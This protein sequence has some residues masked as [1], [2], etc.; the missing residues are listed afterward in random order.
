MYFARILSLL[1]AFLALPVAGQQACLPLQP[2]LEA[3]AGPGDHADRI[4]PGR[5]L[6]VKAIHPDRD[7]CQVAGWARSIAA[8]SEACT[9]CR[10]QA[11][12]LEEL[13][14][15]FAERGLDVLC[16][17]AE[18]GPAAQLWMKDNRVG[19]ALALDPLGLLVDI[20]DPEQGCNAAL[21][22]AH[23]RI[24]WRGDVA[25]LDDAQVEEA[26]ADAF[27]LPLACLGER[28]AGVRQALRRGE[29]SKACARASMLA[30]GAALAAAIE[31]QLDAKVELFE[32]ARLEGDWLGMRLRGD[33]LRKALLGDERREGVLAAL[34]ALE[35]D[36]RARREFAAQREVRATRGMHLSRSK[37]RATA[38]QRL[39][40]IRAE[41]P[42]SV[43]AK[44]AGVLLER[45]DRIEAERQAMR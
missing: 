17:T 29:L 44:E 39:Q 4:L 25:D 9:G 42:A 43:A 33:E 10:R 35:Q 30:D 20:V 32:A 38:R 24:L 5:A 21:A 2:R 27:P 23:G 19:A 22:D 1:V 7:K 45:L 37:E 18:R 26:L 41:L 11:R 6:L 15:R 40:A 34:D 31:R 14:F 36:K 8:G 13:R 3:L 16:V 28:L 12:R